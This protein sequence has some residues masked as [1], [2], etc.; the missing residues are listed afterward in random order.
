[1][2]NQPVKKTS[3]FDYFQEINN[4]QLQCDTSNDTNSIDDIFRSDEQNSTITQDSNLCEYSDCNIM[5]KYFTL[6]IKI[7]T[8]CKHLNFNVSA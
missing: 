7:L 3:L 5:V 2:D 8:W 4:E 1:M 6:I